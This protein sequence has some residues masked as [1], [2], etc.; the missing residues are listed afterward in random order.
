[1]SCKIRVKS[2]F[3]NLYLRFFL[4]LHVMWRDSY[5]LNNT[6]NGKL[7]FFKFKAVVFY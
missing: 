1:M 3:A 7:F 2:L 6:L 4:R 5:N